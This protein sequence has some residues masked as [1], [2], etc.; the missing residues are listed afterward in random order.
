MS[1]SCPSVMAG[2]CSTTCVAWIF[3]DFRTSGVYTF[4]SAIPSVNSGGT[5]SAHR[6]VRFC[7]CASIRRRQAASSAIHLLVLRL[8]EQRLAQRW[9]RIFRTPTHCLPPAP[10]GNGG[11]RTII[12]PRTNVFDAALL[13][14]FPSNASA[15]NSV[16]SLQRNQHSGI[17][18]AQQQLQQQCRRQYYQPVR[19]SARY[20]VRIALI[21]LT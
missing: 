17:R 4:Y 18:S 5:L 20:A 16:R 11:H 2:R 10:I 19:R 15:S 12:G 1:M 3:G 8:K 9:P 14:E 7:R 21:L 13:R 6:P